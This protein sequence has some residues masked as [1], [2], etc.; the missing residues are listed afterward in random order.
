MPT[1]NFKLFDENKA[2]M[3]SDQEYETNNQRL[4]GVQQ[5]IASS[6][7]QNKTMYQVALM[8][9]AIA[10]LMV[11][12]GV[13]AS[14][15][16]AV[17]A[18]VDNLNK[19]LVQKVKDKASEQDLLGF[20]DRDKYVSPGVFAAAAASEDE[21]VSGIGDK[22]YI[23]PVTLW[24]ALA[25]LN[26]KAFVL[27]Q[28]FT[29]SGT[30]TPTPGKVKCVIVAVGFGGDGGNNQTNV[31]GI[32]NSNTVFSA[33][34]GGGGGAIVITNDIL[35]NA[36]PSN[37]NIVIDRNSKKVDVFGGYISAAPGCKG[38]D[39]VKRSRSNSSTLLW[40]GSAKGGAGGSGS[41]KPVGAVEFVGGSGGDGG[42]SVL[43]SN[44]DWTALDNKINGKDGSDAPTASNDSVGIVICAGG[45]GGRGACNR[46][47]TTPTG[48]VFHS[49]KGGNCGNNAGGVAHTLEFTMELHCGASGGSGATY[50]SAGL[51]SNA[52]V[53][54][55]SYEYYSVARNADNLIG[56]GAGGHGGAVGAYSETIGSKLTPGAR[57]GTGAVFIYE[58]V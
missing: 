18:F 3:L 25:A 57:G 35:M 49:G 19:T 46:I 16:A 45:G 2:N 54:S 28:V 27:K 17:S 51:A 38:G 26:S 41:E 30:Y 55:Y 1:S 36:L 21:V 39:N 43:L 13:D 40:S 23:T 9:Y 48:K 56:A 42:Q 10:Q 34:G 4:N 5:G 58:N 31:V 47:E 20:N 37:R 11:Q 53:S 44:G 15:Q 52:L 7:L 32:A 8:T 14:D 22:K 29:S 24:K 50:N 12:N 6:Q 33:S